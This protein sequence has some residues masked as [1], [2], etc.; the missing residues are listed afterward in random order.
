M[1]RMAKQQAI[2]ERPATPV[3]VP[4]TVSKSPLLNLKQVLFVKSSWEQLIPVVPSAISVYAPAKCGPTVA[5]I[6]CIYQDWS[7]EAI[8]Y[9]IQAKSD[10]VWR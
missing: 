3:L 9:L 2:A 6:W 8:L 10:T 5:D 4:I 1:R 7:T